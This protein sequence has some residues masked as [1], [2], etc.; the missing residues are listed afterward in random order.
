MTVLA[1][2]TVVDVAVVHARTGGYQ[3]DPWTPAEVV[4]VD[5]R[6]Y[7]RSDLN[8]D[9]E[10]G[11][12]PIASLPAHATVYAVPNNPNVPTVIHVRRG[13]HVTTYA[14]MGGP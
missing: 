6:H 2:A 4:T 11:E 3:V 13:Q 9:V 14:L 5:H 10:A 7:R 8:T 1:A 12:V